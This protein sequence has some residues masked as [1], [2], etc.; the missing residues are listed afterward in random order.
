MWHDLGSAVGLAGWLAMGLAMIVFWGAVVVGVS[1]LLYFPW[2]TDRRDPNA[3]KVA[4][5]S[6][7]GAEPREPR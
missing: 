3:G 7:P 1:A 4:R 2:T 5:L 6:S